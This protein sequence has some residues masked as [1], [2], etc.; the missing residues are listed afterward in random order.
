MAKQVI[1][2]GS[3]VN[4]GTGDTLRDAFIKTN[5][6][7]TEL[8]V[9]DPIQYTKILNTA[10]WAFY[11][12]GETTPAT[13]TISTTASKLLIDGLGGTSESSYLPLEIR[14][15]AELWDVGNNKITPINIGDSYDVRVSVE[16]TGKTASPNVLDVILDIGGAAGITIPVSEFQ[17]PVVQTPPFT[18]TVAIPIFCLSTFLTNGG[19][20]FLQTDAGTLTVAGRNILIKRDYN[21]A[22]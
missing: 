4:D 22:L 13:Q 1:A 7:F 16:I 20:I 8:Y 21:G 14:G 11:V 10:G 17:I 3:A 12:D 19:Q 9:I 6:N 2:V 18:A 5:D 15:S